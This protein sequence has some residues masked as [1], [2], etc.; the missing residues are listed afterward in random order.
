[1]LGPLKDD[2]VVGPLLSALSDSQPV[3]RATAAGIL[4]E[5][6][7]MKAIAPITGML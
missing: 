4:A 7:E 1:M 3:V 5:R 6:K 2:R